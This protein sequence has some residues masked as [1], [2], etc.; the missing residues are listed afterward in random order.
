MNKLFLLCIALFVL[1]SLTSCQSIQDQDESVIDKEQIT[2]KVAWW[3]GHPRHEYTT[4]IIELF[5]KENP[6]INVEP[7][8][9]NWDDYWKNLAPMAAGNQLPDVIQMD[10]AFLSQYGEKGL[11][12]D[13]TPFVKNNTIDTS[14]IRES[15][16]N[17]GKIG[18]ELYGF[19]VGINVLSVISNEQL[20]DKAGV[21]IYDDTWAW[22]D[23]EQMALDIKKYANVY[24]S[25]GMHPPDIF[26]PYYLRTKGEQ[27]YNEEGTGLAYKN[28]QLFVDYFNMQLRLVEGGAFPTPNEVAAA[29]RGMEDDLIVNG[30][31]AITWNYSNQYA[32]F[33]QLTEA[34]LTLNLPPEHYENQ[35][36]FLK[37]SMLLSIPK[38]SKY[39]E[40]AAK[41]ID[42]FVNN[43]EANKLMK[44]ERGV[45]VSSKISE[46]VKPMLSGEELKIVEYV[47][48]AISLT[49]EMYPPDPTGSSQVIEV[50]KNISDE[51]MYKKITPEEG[52]KKFREHANEI[53]QKG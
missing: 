18:E 22:D 52:A 10:I 27:F 14:S 4:E 17:S 49:N 12:E 23:M 47:E 19:T 13:L 3:G 5:E 21:K 51:I 25:N 53:L 2:I 20:L 26:F 46:E 29:V 43:V 48:K 6:K 24:G 50:L 1:L 28:D 15:V 40:E 42:F 37:P 41:F 8:F 44:G 9:A 7:V 32:S 33:D 35:A 31:S 34:P 16:V 30:K 45:P 39:K 11:L 36:L 38:S